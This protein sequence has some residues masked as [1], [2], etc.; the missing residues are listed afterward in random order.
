MTL[1]RQ[2]DCSDPFLTT[3]SLYGLCYPCLRHFGNGLFFLPLL[4]LKR[5]M[6][7]RL[8]EGPLLVPTMRMIGASRRM[9]RSRRDL[10]EVP[11]MCGPRQLPT[12]KVEQFVIIINCVPISIST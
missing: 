6:R 2:Q 1:V 7:L 8:L 12:I 11:M 3:P 10:D 5:M 4:Q 9:R